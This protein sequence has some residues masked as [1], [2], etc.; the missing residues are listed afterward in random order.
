MFATWCLLI[1]TLLVAM[2]LSGSLL[3]RL[4]INAA[5]L[6]L[7][8]GY[9]MGPQALG[10]IQLD[11][12]RDAQLIERVTE[13]AVLV[14]LFAV[15]LRLRVHLTDRLWR[16]PVL[17]AS[18]AMLLTIAA[19]T[20]LGFWGL[21][22]SLGAAVLLGAVLAPTDPVLASEVQVEEVGDRD[23]LRFSLTAE[24]GLNDGTAFPFVM[25]ALGLLGLHELGENGW[26][27]WAVDVAWAIAGGLLLGWF[28]GTG[29]ARLVLW[30]RRECLQAIGMEN[31]L[32]LGL[33]ALAYGVALKIHAYGFLAVF[34]AGLAMRH[35]E[36][37]DHPAQPA[38]EE[39]AVEP[40]E[41]PY[42]APAAL[43]FAL[44][45]EKLVELTVMLI[46]G[47]LLNAAMLGWHSLG[48]AA[49]LLMVA[50]PAAV[51]LS[52]WHLPWSR[53]Q[54][55]LACWFGVRGVGSLYYLA[56]AESHGAFTPET[57]LVGEAVLVTIAL[58]VLLH[59]STA[60]PVMALYQ[61]RL[62]R[63]G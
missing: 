24:G 38:D 61:R 39:E 53:L 3:K 31:F 47:S 32:A 59:G 9:L 2:G 40:G 55:V 37:V 34:A 56:Y 45:L 7:G 13:V 30:M 14:S 18:V 51:W 33:I 29:F 46:I 11:F 4:P 10:F 58:S 52:T 19:I 44:D 23:R 36:H 12:V 25:L 57:R 60:T 8:V 41:Q 1:G 54:R 63:S 17:L 6:Y 35:V 48:V 50:R 21:G 15:G 28:M 5:M 62:R 22:L 27:W 26:R 16:A 43:E 20:A 42:I 49:V